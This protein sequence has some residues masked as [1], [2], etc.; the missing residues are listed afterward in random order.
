MSYE[1]LRFGWQK[2]L[3]NQVPQKGGGA[4]YG[5]NYQAQWDQAQAALGKGQE[6]GAWAATQYASINA[7]PANAPAIIQNI[8]DRANAELANIDGVINTVSGI[9]DYIF[10]GGGL[11]KDGAL[12][13]LQSARNSIAACISVVPTPIP[14]P[15]P[16]VPP[17]PTS[18]VLQPVVGVLGALAN[19]PP[20]VSVPMPIGD[21]QPIGCIPGPVIRFP[22]DEVIDDNQNPLSTQDGEW[23]PTG[24]IEGVGTWTIE[25][26]VGALPP[27]LALSTVFADDGKSY[28]G[29]FLVPKGRRWSLK[30]WRWRPRHIKDPVPP[31]CYPPFPPPPQ[32]E[33]PKLT[34]YQIL[35]Q[36][37]SKQTALLQAINRVM[38]KP[39]DPVPPEN[40]YPTTSWQYEF[41]NK[42]YSLN[43]ISFAENK[44]AQQNLLTTTNGDF[45]LFKV[46]VEDILQDAILNK[47]IPLPISQEVIP[48]PRCG[49]GSDGKPILILEPVISP[50]P[51]QPDQPITDQPVPCPLPT[52]PILL[53][54]PYFDNKGNRID[55][56]KVPSYL[57]RN[58]QFQSRGIKNRPIDIND[59]PYVPA[60]AP[61]TVPRQD[62]WEDCLVGSGATVDELD[63]IRRAMAQA[64]LAPNA[65]VCDVTGAMLTK[66]RSTNVRDP[67]GMYGKPNPFSGITGVVQSKTSS[68]AALR[69]NAIAQRKIQQA[70]RGALNSRK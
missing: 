6:V 44:A 68:V 4:Y 66:L 32:P 20:P 15:V 18:S 51:Y 3:I 48:A 31:A 40:I 21:F 26:G 16:P 13:T 57:R 67:L 58:R 41:W 61:N 8:N 52:P 60:C 29:S 17:A 65:N 25:R 53:P 36:E 34:E 22:V 63:T 38:N 47:E 46:K 35:L 11:T 42:G 59:L 5:P 69:S 64:K 1:T 56:K 7:N 14:T 30:P 23:E 62:N 70:R 39:V 43:E 55:P 27:G 33:S 45:A 28:G 9:P 12:G 50:Q 54:A 24:T 19:S 2:L 37:V 49:V 10:E